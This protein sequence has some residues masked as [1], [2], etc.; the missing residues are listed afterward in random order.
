[1]DTKSFLIT[2]GAGFI[3]SNICLKLQETG[4]E[5]TALDN[6]EKGSR[7][8]LVEF[9]G[10]IIEGD[11]R[12]FKFGR[13]KVDVIIHEGATTDTTVK[14]RQLVMDV[15]LHSFKNIIDHCLKRNVD[16]VYA[17]SASIY[18]SGKYPMKENQKEDLKE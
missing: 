16:L 17:S 7:G 3:G 4:H 18:G 8:N 1:M 2:G 14:D 9:E 5:V 6:F 12:N 15:N 11:I 10:R 13:E